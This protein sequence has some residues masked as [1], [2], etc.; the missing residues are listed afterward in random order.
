MTS[1]VENYPG[2]AEPILGPELME[3]MRKQ[4][5]RLGAEVLVDDVSRVDFNKH[6]FRVW[7]REMVFE[8]EAMIIEKPLASGR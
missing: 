1:D 7:V 5:E 3:Q 4:A 8:G 6:P 2:F